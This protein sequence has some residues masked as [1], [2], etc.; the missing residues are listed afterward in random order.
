MIAKLV[1]SIISVV[2]KKT[3]EIIELLRIHEKSYDITILN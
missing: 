2:G 1:S 3:V